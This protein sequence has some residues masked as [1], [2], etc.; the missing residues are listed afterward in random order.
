MV[1]HRM[2]NAHPLAAQPMSRI[3][4]LQANMQAGR[5]ELDEIEAEN[6]MLDAHP[7]VAQPMSRIAQLNARIVQQ[8]AELH[9]TLVNNRALEIETAKSLGQPVPESSIDPMMR[10]L[11]STAESGRDALRQLDDMEARMSSRGVR[12]ANLRQQIECRPQTELQHRP[13]HQFGSRVAS[14]P[15]VL[16]S[17]SSSNMCS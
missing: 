17:A 1:E 10:R 6:R 11:M 5:A 15:P 7:T 4:Q 3:A 8:R 16:V 14:R 9:A 12:A 2:L 13:Q